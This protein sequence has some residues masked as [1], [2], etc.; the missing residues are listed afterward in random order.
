MRIS[1]AVAVACL[2]AATH[3]VSAQVVRGRV[4]EVSS[5]A[6]VAGA[7]VSLL[8]ESSDSTIVSV[9][10]GTAG[11][12]AIGARVTGRYRI[13]VKRIGVR[14][15]ISTP[16]DLAEGETRVIDVPIDPIALALPQVTVSGL[17]V[18]RPRELGRISSLWDEARTALEATEISLRD[19]LMEAQLS[20]YAAELDPTNLRVLFD[21][22]SDAQV[23]VSQPFTSLSGDSLSALGYWRVLPGDSVEYLAPDA[24]ALLSNAFL[25]DHCFSMTG[26]P[27]GRPDLV[28]LG[29]S[30]ARDRKLPDITGTVWLDAK[31]FEL[32]FIEFRYTGL[33]VTLPNAD[34]VGGEVHFA[35]LASGAWIVDRWFIRMPQEITMPNQLLS[36]RQLREEGGT[37][38]TAGAVPPV[39]PARVVGMVRDS[40]GRPVAGAVIR[41]IGT[42][43][44]VLSGTDGSYRLDSLPPGPVSIVAHIDGYDALGL[45]AASRR[46][47]VPSGREQ[48]VDLRAPNS[49]TMRNEV[50]PQPVARYMQRTV[51]RAA[52]RLMFVDS[53]TAVPIPGVQFVVSWPATAEAPDADPKIERYRQA[54]SDPRGVAT[55]CDL[56]PGFLLEVSILGG[57]GRR[58]HV[59][60]LTMARSGFA[61]QVIT[62]KL[63]R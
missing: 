20:R 22:R 12:Y 63:N 35:R 47:D 58:T 53:A 44:Q 26:P 25:R 5:G 23:M 33:P 37:V 61:G 13:S 17:C 15:H 2:L 31:R 62:G 3:S 9:L 1:C 54:V 57:G 43:R 27:R 59:M 55:F 46:V 52:L 40:A 29:F 16:F 28:G 39:A 34:R 56:P 49:G 11:D 7:L 41:G 36:R 60:T 6:P 45:L 32:R 30:P 8:G 4:S 38:V 19:R 21:W 24:S 18:T 50:C 42:H 10:T 51:G 48:R 14:R